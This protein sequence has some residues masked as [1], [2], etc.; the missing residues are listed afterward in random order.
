MYKEF[1]QF[2]DNFVW[3]TATASYQIEGACAEDGKGPSIWDTFTHREG[4]VCDGKNAD[5]AID[6]YH[7][8]P[9]DIAIMKQMGLHHY[10]MSISWSRIFPKGRGRVEQK[11][12]DFYDRLI[13]SL[14]LEHITPWVTLYHWD[15]PQALQ[16]EGGWANRATGDAFVEYA[17]LVARHFGD[18][19]KHWITFNEPWVAS[20]C[21]NLY[22]VHAP[23]IKDVRTMLAVSHGMLLAHGKAVRA[24]RSEVPDAKVGIV[25]NLAWVEPATNSPEDALAAQRWD[26]AF[27]RWFMDPVF[28]G[29]YPED[30][31]AYFGDLVPPIE[32]DDLATIAAPTDFFGLNYYTRRVVAHDD[33]DSF[34]Q[35]KQIYR[36]YVPRA[37][38][39]EFENWPEGLYRVLTNLKEKY[40]NLPVYISENGTTCLDTLD[41]DGCVHDPVRVDYLRNHFA[42]AYQAIKE[43]CDVRGYFVWS[44]VDN[45]EWGFGFSKRFGLVYIDY[46]DNLRRIL[47]DSSHFYSGVIHK[48]GFE[49]HSL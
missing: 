25:N 8:Y 20:I 36:A 34:I 45:F 40:G 48:N 22:G 12:L 47:K 46:D 9:E 2:P 27:N 17:T 18:R 21:G 30:M 3:G 49:V 39:E 11:G 10:R 13:D 44:L 1:L 29:A 32:K 7:R 23:G 19:V 33:G 43:G 35:A 26:G 14:L 41:F 28:K 4:T 42:A 31:L 38:F 37:E 24:I 15:L 5:Q 16:D 6:H